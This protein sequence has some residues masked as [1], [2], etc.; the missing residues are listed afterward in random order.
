MSGD[1]PAIVDEV[2]PAEAYQI[3]A[4]KSDAILV[5]VRSRA[6]WAFIG[7]PDLRGLGKTVVPVEWV[8]FPT[9]APNAHFLDQLVQAAGGQLPGHVLFICRSGARSMAA[10]QM[11]AGSGQEGVQRC[12]NVAEGFEGDLDGEGHR[13][14]VN[15][16]KV[17][18]LPW[19][20]S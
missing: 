15:G 10:A 4:D 12:S 7:L 9:M 19:Q 6:E 16:W 13:G 3:L 11:V 8:S 20:Q 2:G 17:H 5:D 1:A 14:S 18:G